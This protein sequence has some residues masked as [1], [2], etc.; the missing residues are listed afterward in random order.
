MT[1]KHAAVTM[2]RGVQ[3]VG[4]SFALIQ[5]IYSSAGMASFPGAFRHSAET[6]DFLV[7]LRIS[8]ARRETPETFSEL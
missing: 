8:V 4:N 1:G 2:M 6:A 7:A 3:D 5:T